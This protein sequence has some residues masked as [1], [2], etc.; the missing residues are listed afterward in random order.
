M[1]RAQDIYDHIR[2]KAAFTPMP[3]DMGQGGGPA[4]Q[5]GPPMGGPAPQGGPPMGGPPAGGPPQG[6]QQ[7]PVMQLV[8]MLMQ[9]PQELQQIMANPQAA[10]QAMQQQGVP[11]ELLMQALQVIQQMQGGG[12]AGPGAMP[13]GAPPPGGMA[14]P[15]EP[16][17]PPPSDPNVEALGQALQQ[18]GAE[19]TDLKRAIANGKDAVNPELEKRISTTEKTIIRVETKL[20]EVLKALNSAGNSR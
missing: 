3:P 2:S 5:G 6:G 19:L 18:M 17:A 9:S 11:P 8:E 1:I 16:A 15:A 13:P 14:P 4:P 10:A 12:Q 20:D 7:D